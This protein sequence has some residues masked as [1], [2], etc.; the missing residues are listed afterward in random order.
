MLRFLKLL[1]CDD[2]LEVIVLSLHLL[3]QFLVELLILLLIL[4]HLQD[5]L[6]D[7][8][9]DLVEDEDDDEV[10]LVEVEVVDDDEEVGNIEKNA[11]T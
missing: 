9:A 4:W 7:D 10:D 11:G 2:F 6:V 8:E 5:I 3:V 1:K